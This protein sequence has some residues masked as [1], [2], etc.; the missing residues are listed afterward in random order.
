MKTSGILN[1]STMDSRFH[2]IELNFETPTAS[3]GYNAA[4]KIDMENHPFA[5]EVHCK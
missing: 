4:F 5:Y 2:R 3:V 1:P